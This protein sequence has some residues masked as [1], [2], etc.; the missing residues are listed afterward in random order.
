MLRR[1]A[2]RLATVSFRDITDRLDSFEKEVIELNAFRKAVEATSPEVAKKANALIGESVGSTNGCRTGIESPL[3]ADEFTELNQFYALQQ[4]RD[5]HVENLLYINTPS[6][7]MQ[8]AATVHREYLVRAAQRARKLNAAPYGLS[9]MPSIKELKQWYQWTFHDMRNSQKPSD[10]EGAREFDALVRRVFLRH[11]NVSTLLNDGFLELARREHWR[12][13]TRELRSSYKELEEFFTEFCTGRV[14]LRFLIGNY[15]YLSTKIL[16]VERPEYVEWDP[17][18]L[19]KPLFFD[20]NPEDFV[21]QI[22][23]KTSLLNLLKY[24][25][26]QTQ[27]GYDEEEIVLRL[28]G[29]DSLTF[30]GIPYITCDVLTAMLEDAVQANLKR[31]EAFGVPC[32]KIEVTLSQHSKSKNYVVRVSDTAGGVPLSEAEQALACWSLYKAVQEGGQDKF[33]TWTQSPIRLPYAWC[34]A[35]VIGGDITL[36]SIEGYGTDRQLYLPSSGI[37]NCR[38]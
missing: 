19:T 35:R 36:A 3:T 24:S 11:Y 38:I 18:G 22:C 28:A 20:H 12:E 7:L 33:K 23:R 9:Q 1:A 29:E 6:T 2:A 10:I 13:V 17:E 21:G 34:A 4:S 30:V 5:I 14:R 15:M 32:S 16:N 8:H 25:I 31:Q 37:S 27:K 26:R